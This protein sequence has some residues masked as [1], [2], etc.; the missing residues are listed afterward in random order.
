[1]S[2]C[3]VIQF[4][5]LYGIIFY[6]DTCNNDVDIVTDNT[7]KLITGR[8]LRRPILKFSFFVEGLLKEVYYVKGFS[9]IQIN[10]HLFFY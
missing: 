9:V 6:D 4:V 10:S 5:G 3:F 7:V 8:F 1:M 2:V